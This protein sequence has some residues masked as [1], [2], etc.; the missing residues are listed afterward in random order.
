M[1]SRELVT[2]GDL[3]RALILNAARGR[4]AIAAG[5]LVL[6][7]AIALGAPW[8]VPIALLTYAG[9]AASTF[10]DGD[11][12]ERVGREVYERRRPAPALRPLP[13]ELTPDLAALVE[14]ARVEERRVVEAIE[15]A[16]L[17]LAEVAVEV[18]ALAAEMERIAGRAQVVDTYLASHDAAELRRRRGELAP[19]DDGDASV[20]DARRRA[21]AVIDDQLSLGDSLAGELRRFQAEMEHLIA[22]LAVVHGQI[23]RISVSDDPTAQASVARDVRELRGR[24]GALADYL[25]V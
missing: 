25:R 18:E 15:A 17:P 14:R 7:A 22:S 10:F 1:A 2:R 9:L 6:V 16:E 3:R 13:K 19:E 8:L 23:V 11:V 5:V 4:V 12:A 24:V 21:V 20:A